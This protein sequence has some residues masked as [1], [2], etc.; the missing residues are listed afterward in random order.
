[1]GK[2]AKKRT[3]NY[4][5]HVGQVPGALSLYR[6]KIGKNLHIE[7]FDYTK[8]KIEETSTIKY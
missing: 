3:E 8:D 4:K 2:T 7:C 1:M 6:E 5:K